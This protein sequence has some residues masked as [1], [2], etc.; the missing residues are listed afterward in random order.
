MQ[1]AE[2]FKG[3][4]TLI[5]M[6]IRRIKQKKPAF[7]GFLTTLCQ[8]TNY[9]VRIKFRDKSNGAKSFVLRPIY[10]VEK[11]TQS[12]NILSPFRQATFIKGYFELN[13]EYKNDFQMSLVFLTLC[14]REAAEKPFARPG[15][16][17]KPSLAT[18][19]SVCE[20]FFQ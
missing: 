12:Q 9:R 11:W 3:I 15:W 20:L 17:L 2:G 18:A 1:R 14:R 5:S 7:A 19:R 16:G 13:T 4:L 10:H 8:I 6:Q